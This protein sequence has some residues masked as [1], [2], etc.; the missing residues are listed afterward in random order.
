MKP[1]RLAFNHTR[2]EFT[3]GVEG[4]IGN[5]LGYLLDR[6]HTVDFFGGKVGAQLTHPN[7]RLVRVPYLRSPRPLRVASFARWSR[8]LIEREERVRPYD[9]VQG[10]SRTYYHTLYR[11]GSGCRQDFCELY[12]DRFVR[13]GLRKLY[14]GWNPVD[15]IVRRIEEKRY[16]ERPQRLVI[17]ISAFVRDQ[18]LRHYPVAPETVRVIYSGVDCERFH[19]R[20]RGAGRAKIA[21]LLGGEEK[22]GARRVLAFVGND[23]HRKGLD[24]VLEALARR[25]ARSAGDGPDPVLVVAGG[26]SRAVEYERRAVSLGLAGSAFF[27]GKR[28][29]VPEILAGAD[30]LPP[31]ELLRRLRK[32]LERGARERDAGHRLEHFGRLGAH[33]AEPRLGPAEKRRRQPPRNDRKL[34]R[35]EGPRAHACRGADCSARAELGPPLS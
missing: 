1:L 26:D 16:V 25:A 8:R 10:F 22:L 30:V 2:L 20:W 34:S 17:A 31:A 27:L 3:G 15:R 19:P 32:R 5:L 28:S 9:I 4:Y 13:R 35:G 14:Y 33:P 29:D 23:Y 21:A 18:I 11:D 12:L 7:F 24:L 6:G